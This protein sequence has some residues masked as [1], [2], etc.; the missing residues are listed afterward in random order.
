ML[1]PPS[2]R[3][4]AAVL[5]GNGSLQCPTA[6]YPGRISLQCPTNKSPSNAQLPTTSAVRS[7]RILLQCRDA[8]HPAV[9]NRRVSLQRPTAEYP[10][11]AQPTVSLQCPWQR[12][13]AVPKPTISFQCSMAK[14]P[15]HAQPLQCRTPQHLPLC[16]AAR[17]TVWGGRETLHFLYN[18]GFRV[19]MLEVNNVS[20]ILATTVIP[21]F[22]FPLLLPIPFPSQPTSCHAR[23]RDG[24][25][26]LGSLQIQWQLRQKGSSG[27]K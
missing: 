10:C 7:R 6:K 9:P 23:S 22:S 12:I 26:K 20:I 3:S 2:A 15:C 19:G 21:N 16:S 25:C 13:P 4:L 8:E 11:S 18:N 27:Y 5:N 17:K 1:S 14:Y 24:V